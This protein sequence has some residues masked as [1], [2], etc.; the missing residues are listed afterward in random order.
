MPEWIA[1]AGPVVSLVLF[2]LT[3]ALWWVLGR[4]F[5]SR[6]TFT[7]EMAET[8]RQVGAALDGQREHAS[9]DRVTHARLDADMAHLKAQV[10]A[11]PTAHDIAG[12][13]LVL[14]QM[15][16][17]TVTALSGVKETVTSV[18]ARLEAEGP[19]RARIMRAVEHHGRILAEAA[20]DAAD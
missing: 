2:G 14:E 9:E 1:S 17:E 16:V 12:L 20:R 15:R 18:Q 3:P 13:R 4:S 19:E 7:A 5:V 11:L 8:R 6:D 10:S